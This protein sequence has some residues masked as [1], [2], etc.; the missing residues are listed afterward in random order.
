MNLIK[1]QSELTATIVKIDVKA[2]HE[3]MQELSGCGTPET[4]KNIFAKIT[5]TIVVVSSH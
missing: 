5:V 1:S 4:C 2:G 3:Q